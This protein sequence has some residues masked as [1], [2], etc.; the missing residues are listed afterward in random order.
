MLPQQATE[1]SLLTPQV[2]SPPGADGDEGTRGRRGLAIVGSGPAVLPQQ[3]TEP[4]LLTPQVWPHP[5]LTETKEPAGGV[6]CHRS[7]HP[8]PAGDGAVAPHPAGVVPPGA[9]G[10]EGTR[11]RR[12]LAIEVT[13][14]A[15]DGAVA[16]H[17]AGVAPPGADGDEGT[18]GR[19]GLAVLIAA[20]AGDG[21]VA[22]HP[23]GVVPPALT[24]TKEPAGG[25]AWPSSSSQPQQAT[26]PSLLTPQV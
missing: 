13:A 24:E 23:A 9:D 21:A 11:G 2:W 8:A 5:A 19:R 6:A 14:P 15:G 18:R 25:V 7:S 22:P 3:A 1:P 17:P 4:S 26:E 16:P 20:P 10:D 12:G